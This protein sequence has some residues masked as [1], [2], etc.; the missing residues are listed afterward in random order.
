MITSLIRPVGSVVLP[1]FAGTRLYMRPHRLGE[2]V[3][4]PE[5]PD[6]EA[7]VEEMLR[8]IPQ[9]GTLVHLTM[10]QKAVQF[11]MTHRR[12]GTHIDGNY[13]VQAR[14]WGSWVIPDGM[15]HPEWTN[16]GG[17]IMAS[18]YASCRAW[19]GDVAG[20]PGLNGDCEHML[21]K[22][23]GLETF[24]LESN[25][26]YLGNSTCVHKPL[27]LD[28]QVNRTLIRITLPPSFQMS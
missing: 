15:T 14:G 6:F 24:M 2:R 7:P 27:P 18:D 22:L 1:A 20:M 21:D 8:H 13:D 11:G 28:K 5:N 3:R 4:V 9:D 26:I 10:D 19:V 12:P 17:F 25:Q 23:E 16:K